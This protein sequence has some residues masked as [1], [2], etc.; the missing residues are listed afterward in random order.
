MVYEETR[1]KHK[2]PNAL[3]PYYSFVNFELYKSSQWFSCSESVLGYKT[4]FC[5][6]YIECEGSRYFNRHTY[7]EIEEA[8]IMFDVDNVCLMGDFN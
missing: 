3:L 2:I 5:P 1:F 7:A 6:V 4:L 8:L